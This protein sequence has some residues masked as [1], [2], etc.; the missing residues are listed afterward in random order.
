MT[1]TTDSQITSA[2]AVTSGRPLVTVGL[3]VFNGERFL[4]EALESLRRHANALGHPVFVA[5]IDA[6]LEARPV[7]E[8]EEAAVEGDGAGLNPR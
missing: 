4:R 2:P 5:R 8:E 6:L 1:G 3:P 7:E